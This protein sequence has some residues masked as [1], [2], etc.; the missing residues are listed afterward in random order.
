MKV[1]VTGASGYVG[2]HVFAYL[3]KNGV[4]AVGIDNFSN[5]KQEVLPR[6]EDLV[7]CSI[8]FI[9]CDLRETSQVAAIFER[10]KP[11]VVFHF[12]GLKAVKES[13]QK[14]LNYYDNNVQGTVSLLQAMDKVKCY[15]LIF[16]FLCNSLW[17]TGELTSK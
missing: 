2:S 16:F 6:L 10:T 4:S 17:P 11:G 12:A 7:K 15:N 14:P 3:L 13:S 9:E 5:S 1:L 8:N